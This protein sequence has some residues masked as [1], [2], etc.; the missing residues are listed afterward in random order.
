MTDLHVTDAIVAG[1]QHGFQ[2][3][4]THL[5]PVAQG[6]MRL[7]TDP[8]GATAMTGGLTGQDGQLAFLLATVGQCLT[9]LAQD[10]AQAGQQFGSTDQ[11]LA[12]EVTDR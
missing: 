11:A 3:A 9:R 6:V 2:A 7:D 1:S 4:A 8:A 10:T 12:R 5:E